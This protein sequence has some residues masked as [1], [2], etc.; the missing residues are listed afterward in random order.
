MFKNEQNK[1]SLLQIVISNITVVACIQSVALNQFYGTYLENTTAFCFVPFSKSYHNFPVLHQY[2]H[3]MIDKMVIE[4]KGL[5]T[6]TEKQ[7]FRLF[8]WDK[9]FLLEQ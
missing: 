4:E 3:L 1:T 6:Q 9:Y 2:L 8:K 7:Q 5:M